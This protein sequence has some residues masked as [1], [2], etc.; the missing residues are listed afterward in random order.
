[1]RRQEW[2]NNWPLP[3]DTPELEARLN[4]DAAKHRLGNLTLVAQS[5]NSGLSNGP[6]VA[7]GVVPQKREGLRKH[8][9]YMLNKP[10]VELPDWD[11]ERIQQRG[12][13]LA[14]LVLKIWPAPSAFGEA[15]LSI[16][17]PGVPTP[18]DVAEARMFVTITGR[19][20]RL[21]DEFESLTA[22]DEVD[23]ALGD[24]GRAV[25]AWVERFRDMSFV[26][27]QRLPELKPAVTVHGEP[28]TLFSLT[29]E[30]RVY[31]SADAWDRLPSFS[32]VEERK[33]FLTRVNEAVGASMRGLKGWSYFPAS[34]LFDDGRRLAFLSLMEELADQLRVFRNSPNQ[35]RP[36]VEASAEPSGDL[37][38]RY[39]RFFT[40]VLDR[41][42]SGDPGISAPPMV[43]PR[44][45]LPFGAGRTG[46]AFVWS[47]SGGLAAARRVVH[48]RRG[49][50]HEQTAVR[51]AQYG[52]GRDRRG[53]GCAC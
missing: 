28:L 24:V 9:V 34:L 11:E 32:D 42:M 38:L 45:W 13:E 30:N 5:L 17:E 36:F 50:G 51:S 40:S 15:G 29:K 12:E 6:W 19:R 49:S 16:P 37:A 8:N 20:K 48:R 46:F 23:P 53:G 22:L 52:C 3:R 10:L 18:P 27:A 41:F 31:L 33:R 7:D 26:K 1:M 25:M 21:W 39:Q 14:G 4:R 2:S 47:I 43:G 44:N 35:A